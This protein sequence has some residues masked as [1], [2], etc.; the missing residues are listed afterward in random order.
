MEVPQEQNKKKTILVVDDDLPVLS[1]IVEKLERE[2]FVALQARNGEDGLVSALQAHPNLILLDIVMPKM[3]GISM[4]KK[5]RTTDDWGK[6]VPVIL[7]TNLSPDK[8]NFNKGTEG[9]DPAYYL[10][11]ANWSLSDVVDKIKE[12]LGS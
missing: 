3:D 11:K 4:L 5:L 2:G 8:E 12:V 7:L 1:A 9:C 10:I 6:G